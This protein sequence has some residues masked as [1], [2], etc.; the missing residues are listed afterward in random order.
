MGDITKMVE[1]NEMK[2]QISPSLLAADF[3]RLGE[4]L[5]KIEAAGADMIHLDVMDGVFVPNISFGM[6]VIASLRKTSRLFFDVHIMIV[7]PIRYI[8]SLAKAGADGITFHVEAAE[9]VGAVIQ[10]IKGHGMKAGLT[11][12]PGTP[13][14]K[15]LPWLPQLDL[16]LVMSVEPGFGG[17]SFMAGMM[18][19][20]AAIRS[21]AERIGRPDLILQ[22]D[23]GVDRNTAAP[24]GKAGASCLV[25]GSAVFGKGDY[26]AEIA[27][28]RAAAAG[29]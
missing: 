17:Q 28:I 29:A 3:S 22:V 5:E 14:E 24:C 23:G 12:R 8:D 25:A 2:M 21:E 1:R 13:V 9:D 18:D 20:V 10:K 4:E 11:L 7:D 15:V 16:A 26:A 27:A 6:S 19:K